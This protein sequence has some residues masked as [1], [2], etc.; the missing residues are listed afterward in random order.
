ML[1]VVWTSCFILIV[2][3]FT[4][5]VLKLSS[6]LSFPPVWGCERIYHFQS[7]FVWCHVAMTQ[8][9]SGV[10]FFFPFLLDLSLFSETI[11]SEFRN[12]KDK[13]QP[14]ILALTNTSQ[15]KTSS[16]STSF[17]GNVDIWIYKCV[18]YGCSQVG[19]SY[20]HSLLTPQRISSH[21]P[22]FLVPK[23]ASAAS[24]RPFITATLLPGCTLP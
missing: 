2:F 1:C 24:L 4:A 18:L 5:V 14:C 10:S 17:T 3:V 7:P 16:L 15:N 6:C 21:G 13:H 11:H 23:W 9:I 19:L 8:L 20:T 22:S 12:N